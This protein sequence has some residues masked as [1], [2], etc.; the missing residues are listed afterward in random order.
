MNSWSSKNFICPTPLLIFY[1]KEG[2]H[3]NYHWCISYER[4]KP[5]KN[6]IDNRT[7]ARIEADLENKPAKAKLNK[8]I[9]NSTYG[10]LSMNLR[11]WI[12]DFFNIHY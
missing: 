10:R 8:D 1:L 7:Q 6:F 3:V 4:G 11:F 9:N 12:K 5:F 2:C